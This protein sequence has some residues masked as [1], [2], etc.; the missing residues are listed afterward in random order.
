MRAI[1]RILTSTAVIGA[2]ISTATA[3]TPTSAYANAIDWDAI[4]QCESGGDWSINTGN[5]YF[6]GLQFKPSTW[7]E[8]G[9]RGNPANAARTE[10][11]LIAERV[12]GTQGLGAWPVCG[13]QGVEHVGWYAPTRP[14]NCQAVAA[15][16]FGIIDLRR[17]C[18]TLTNPGRILLGGA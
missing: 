16:L 15:N 4:A 10:Q 17:L 14:T 3:A 5:G 1:C 18:Q 11:I 9:G 13:R 2:L 7:A 12:I 8:H 6:G